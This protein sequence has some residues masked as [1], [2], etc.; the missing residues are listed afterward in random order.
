[1]A[2]HQIPMQESDKEKTVLGTP[3]GGLYQYIVMPFGL[4]NFPATFQRVIEQ[5]LCGLQWHVAVL[6]LDDI[7]VYSQDF[8]EHL[9][10]L[11][12]VFDRL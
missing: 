5:T 11:D 3:R 7:I 8:E 2:Y 9:E 6:Y 1:M 12:L 4:C 10:G